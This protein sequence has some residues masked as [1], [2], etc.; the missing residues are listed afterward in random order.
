MSLFEIYKVFNII[1]PIDST[2]STVFVCWRGG[3]GGRAWGGH[4][5]VFVVPGLGHL[6]DLV[7]LG[8]GI[9]ETFFARRGDI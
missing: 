5:V 7:L 2:V 6:T 3:G 4:L 8:L 1:F 9:F